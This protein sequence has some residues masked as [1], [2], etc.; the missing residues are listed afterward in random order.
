[1]TRKRCA[2]SG[3]WSPLAR[4]VELALNTR[5]NHLMFPPRIETPR[6][7]LLCLEHDLLSWL[8]WLP[9]NPPRLGS[10]CVLGWHECPTTTQPPQQTAPRSQR[11][12][13]RPPSLRFAGPRSS[14]R[15]RCRSSTAPAAFAR[16][17]LGARAPPRRQNKSR[18]WAEGTLPVDLP[19]CFARLPACFFF[20]SRRGLSW[21]QCVAATIF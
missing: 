12:K 4:L 10:F 2:R 8:S 16:I 19:I 5:R 9:S 21:R 11:P 20:F 13:R 6:T 17:A 18:A 1:M 3:G 14:W 7:R 15:R